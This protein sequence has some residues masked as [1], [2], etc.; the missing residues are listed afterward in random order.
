[1]IQFLP[2]KT[3]DIFEQQRQAH[4]A[5]KCDAGQPHAGRVNT[6]IS[7]ARAALKLTAIIQ[8]GF[9]RQKGGLGFDLQKT[10][11]VLAGAKAIIGDHPPPRGGLTQARLADF[12]SRPNQ[13]RPLPRP[14][15]R[16]AQALLQKLHLERRIYSDIQEIWN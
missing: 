2:E 12:R 14:L 13:R 9:D 11:R 10:T 4:P 16:T 6:E 1:M 3:C 8:D 7:H 5:L 15:H